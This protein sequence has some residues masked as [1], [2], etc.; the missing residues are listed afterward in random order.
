[1]LASLNSTVFSCAN[2]TYTNISEISPSF[3]GDY[4]HIGAVSCAPM[5]QHL[6]RATS[7]AEPG[8]GKFWRIDKAHDCYLLLRSHFELGETGIAWRREQAAKGGAVSSMYFHWASYHE[9]TKGLRPKDPVG[10][11]TV[12]GISSS[13]Q[14]YM[15]RLPRAHAEVLMLVPRV[16][17][18]CEADCGG[19]RRELQGQR[20][21]AHRPLLRVDERD[22]R[23]EERRRRRLCGEQANPGARLCP[24]S[25]R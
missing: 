20:V 10:H 25:E 7:I 6:S 17:P 13:Y 11:G 4:S 23:P 15:E 21:R 2:V 8:P 16:P 12:D 3:M 1:M 18:R 22:V 14:Y 5:A 19:P 9:E 24:C